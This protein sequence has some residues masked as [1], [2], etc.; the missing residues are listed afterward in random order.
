MPN[1]QRHVLI[2]T[3]RNN[4][5]REQISEAALLDIY[6]GQLRTVANAPLRDAFM[7][8]D[9]DGVVRFALGRNKDFALEVHYRRNAKSPWERLPGR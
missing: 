2:A 1:D 4:K 9:N 6:S 7:L 3:Y 5:G 8:A